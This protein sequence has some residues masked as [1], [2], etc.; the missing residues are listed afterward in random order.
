[1]GAQAVLQVLSFLYSFV[2]KSVYKFVYMY[3]CVSVCVLATSRPLR[4][5]QELGAWRSFFPMDELACSDVG[6]QGVMLPVFSDVLHSE[7]YFVFR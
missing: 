1:M 7:G 3:E 5:W 6:I 4:S 2:L